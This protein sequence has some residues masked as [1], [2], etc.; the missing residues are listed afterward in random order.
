MIM[1]PFF[2]RLAP[3]MIPVA[4]QGAAR[5]R[6][7]GRMYHL[8]YKGHLP[9]A[10]LLHLL[11][12]ISRTKVIGTSICHEESDADAP[13]DHTHFAWLWEKAVDLIGCDIM[14]VRVGGVTIHP[15]IETKKSVAWIE[16][17]FVQYHLGLKTDE[18]GKPKYVKPVALYQELPQSFE[19]SE[20]LATEVAEASDL[21]S[22][23]VAA[24]IRPRSVSDVMLL[25]RHKRPPPF[26]HNF[27]RDQFKPQALPAD[28]KTRVTG[29]LQIH[30]AVRLGKTEWACAQFDNPLLVTSRDALREFRAGVHDG[31]VI[32][33]MVFN[34]WTVTDAEALTDWTQPAQIKVLYG[35]AKI[36]KHTVKII[37]TNRKDVWPADPFGQ[38]VGRR[39]SQMEVVA[40]M[41]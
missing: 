3:I 6:W 11:S 18:S 4:P 40:A 32:D 17:I 21:L 22:G 23:V 31:I 38:L 10:L 35:I 13:Y 19:W 15:N 1:T 7:R 36:P 33:K 28:F 37:V 24:G 34:D 39:V 14:D 29:T 9:A 16:R 8:T 27:T 20:Y 41:F 30:G 2:G 26:D 25:Q 12:S 5:F